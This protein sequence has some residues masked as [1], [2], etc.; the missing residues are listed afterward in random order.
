MNGYDL[1]QKLNAMS[2]DELEQPVRLINEG[3]DDEENIW[4]N[5][6]EVSPK[7]SRGYEQSGEIR[8]IGSE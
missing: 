2:I 3:V 8:I 4:V 7:G 5:D 1:L 6:I